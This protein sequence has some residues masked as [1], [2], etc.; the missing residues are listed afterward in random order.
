MSEVEIIM[1][2]DHS[3]KTLFLNVYLEITNVKEERILLIIIGD[4]N[5]KL[6][7][8]FKN[9]YIK[10]KIFNSIFE[11]NEKKLNYLINMYKPH[12]VLIEGDYL[13]LKN[14]YKLIGSQEVKNSLFITSI[15]DIMNSK[16][17]SKILKY[18]LNKI[19]SNIIIINN[20]DRF[21]INDEYIKNIRLKHA[22]S[23]LF[24][25]EDFEEIYFKFKNYGLLKSGF[26]KNVFKYLKEYI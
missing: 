22:N 7:K 1:G 8:K 4:G 26:H 3:G 18:K 23:F 17:I 19:G 13:S 20:F 10:V 15:I 5:T 9:V 16:Y 21:K 11:I 24:Y 14:I 12:R 6:E 2:L 25:I